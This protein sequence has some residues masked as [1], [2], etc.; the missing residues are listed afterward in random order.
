MAEKA[1]AGGVTMQMGRAAEGTDLPVAE[2]SGNGEI[3]DDLSG[4]GHITVSAT[5]QDRKSVV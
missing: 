2:A 5:E 1:P 4:D 3:G